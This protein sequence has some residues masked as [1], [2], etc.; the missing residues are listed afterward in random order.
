MSEV[1]Q[2]P[3][4]TFNALPDSERT[5]DL[6]QSFKKQYDCD[7]EYVARAPGRVS[8]IGGES[9]ELAVDAELN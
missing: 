9:V 5:R 7:A 1:M 6:L 2:Q 4:T 3:I 8:I